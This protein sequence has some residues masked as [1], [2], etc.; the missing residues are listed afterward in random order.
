MRDASGVK[1]GW[2]CLGFQGRREWSVGS[3]ARLVVSVSVPVVGIARKDFSS[4][5]LGERARVSELSDA[6]TRV[7]TFVE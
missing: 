7:T 5:V 1:V 6:K 4:S 2:S 3:E